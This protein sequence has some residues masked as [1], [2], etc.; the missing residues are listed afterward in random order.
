M[1]QRTLTKNTLFYGDNL[2]IL[3]QY[4]AAE[5]IDLIYLDPP[6]NSNRNYNVLYKEESSSESTSQ[7]KAFEDTWHW[8]RDTE[9]QYRALVARGA[10]L[11]TLLEALVS[12]NGRNQMTAYLVMM[13]IRLVELHRALKP[14]GS[15]Y[16]HCDPTASHYLKMVL[17]CIL[18]TKQF[19]NELVWCYRGA[20]YPKKDFGRRHDI[21]FRYSKTDDL[22]FN[23][24]EVREEYAAA[25]KER[26]KH[27]I[28]NV[29]GKHDFGVQQLHPLG[30]QPDDWWQIQPIAPSAKERLGYPTQKPLALLERIIQASS[31]PGDVILDPFCG[32]GTAVH[33]AQKLGRIWVGIDLTPLATTLIKSRLY[34]AFKLEAKKDY[35]LL[36]EPVTLADAQHLALQDRYQFQWW[37]LGLLPAYP[38][39]GQGD[40]KQS[41]KG[42]DKGIDGIMTFR[43]SGDLHEKRIIVQVKSGKVSSRDLRALSGTIER[44]KNAVLGVFITLEPP[45]RNMELEILEIGPWRST[46][47]QKD[48]PKIQILTIEQLLNGAKV[49]FPGTDT[50]LKRAQRE[51]PNLGEQKTLL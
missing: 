49:Q 35:D 47:W 28:G 31:N 42:S 29:R 41:K 27:H 43:D 11:G 30:K 20:G 7:I 37:A 21:I 6:F 44:E 24:D 18:G 19:R 8:N 23:L 51:E 46:V 34:S 22:V 45:S 4:V 13:A 15:L 1:Y 12:V 17:D 32:C 25:T 39:G 14:T 33:A 36:G 38:Y 3:R 2:D 48:Y 5:S 50:T 10:K 9:E 16:L 26:F 40:S